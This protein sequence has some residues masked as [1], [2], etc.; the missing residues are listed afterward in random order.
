M[1]SG[2]RHGADCPDMT[3]YIHAPKEK[4]TKLE[5]SGKKGTFCGIQRVS[6]GD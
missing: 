5:P 1:V 6:Y 2:L 4:R 3:V